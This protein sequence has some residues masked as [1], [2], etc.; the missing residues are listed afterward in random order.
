MNDRLDLN[1]IF[2]LTIIFG[3]FLGKL[4]NVQGTALKDKI[5]YPLMS[6]GFKTGDSSGSKMEEILFIPTQSQPD[7]ENLIMN[8]YFLEDYANWKRDLIDEG[9]SSKMSIVNS[10]NSLFDRALYMNQTGLGTLTFE[11]QIP[12]S[13]IDLTFSATFIMKATAGL[14]Y[15]FSGSG[16]ALIV[17]DYLDA[18]GESLGFTRIL[19]VN[20][21]LF[22]GSAFIGAPEKIS[23]TNYMHNIQV[24]SDK[25]YKNYELNISKE[26]NENLL[27][28]NSSDIR[29]IKIVLI[30][31]SNDKNASGTLTV[32]DLV[33]KPNHQ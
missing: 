22:A 17:I 33:L 5:S 10:Q 4:S 28:I 31:G 12:I 21:N 3:L 9:G 13:S 24:E 8:A 20:E 26:V 7:P 32:S 6:A 1:R 16:Y 15:G 14:I 18:A 30:V 2:F 23:D 25:V 29:S 19:N 27:G 11:Q